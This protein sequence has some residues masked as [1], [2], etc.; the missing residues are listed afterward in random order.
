M[1]PDGSSKIQPV[2]T[3]KPVITSSALAPPACERAE[4]AT[5]P[6]E[7][8]PEGPARLRDGIPEKNR[9][10]AS[11]LVNLRGGGV[12]APIFPVRV[13]GRLRPLATK[14]R[15]SFSRTRSR[16]RSRRASTPT[17]AVTIATTRTTRVCAASRYGSRPSAGQE[18]QS[19]MRSRLMP[20]RCSTF[21]AALHRFQPGRLVCTRDRQRV[22][23]RL[24]AVSGHTTTPAGAAQFDPSRS[25]SAHRKVPKADA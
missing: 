24:R 1:A 19:C 16:T 6:R 9:R 17:L 2:C 20:S 5:P 12:A 10:F 14:S 25:E 3:T 18:R 8:S 23:R 13:Y 21:S 7:V 15:E 4:P 22:G 11:G